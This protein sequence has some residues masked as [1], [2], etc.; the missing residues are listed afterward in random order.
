MKKIIIINGPMGVGKT[1]IGK[2]LCTK[3]NRS[4]FL[5]G[6]W[7]FDLH[8]FVATKETKKM[9]IDNITHMIRN[10]MNCSECEYIIFNWLIDQERV[11]KDI[12]E[13]ISDLHYKLYQITLTCSATALEKRWYNDK[14]NDWRIESWLE[15]SKKS[16]SYFEN[17]ETLKVD[18]SDNTPEYIVKKIY[19]LIN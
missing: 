4:A 17:L 19:D 14:I 8:P 10:Y 12:L 9:A 3:L 2:L 15:I 5:D 7:C 13:A 18:T 6:D 11:Y 16:L 1:T